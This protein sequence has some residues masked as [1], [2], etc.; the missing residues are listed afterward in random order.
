MISLNEIMAERGS[1]RPRFWQT[2]ILAS[3]SSRRRHGEYE[4]RSAQHSNSAKARFWPWPNGTDTAQYQGIDVCMILSTAAMHT[5]LVSMFRLASSRPP[6][7]ELLR[8]PTAAAKRAVPKSRNAAVTLQ[9]PETTTCE[10]KR[11]KSGAQF[12]LTAMQLPT[13]EMIGSQNL[14]GLH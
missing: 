13:A 6:T 1:G 3:V 8:P 11:I 2:E 9:S 12:C 10:T 5:R 7:E 4:R 14:G